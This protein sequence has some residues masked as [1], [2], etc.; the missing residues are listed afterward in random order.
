MPIKGLAALETAQPAPDPHHIGA[1]AALAPG[2]TVLNLIEDMLDAE[3]GHPDV[4][5]SARAAARRAQWPPR[6]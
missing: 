5:S 6:A 4:S 1:R 2:A 3:A